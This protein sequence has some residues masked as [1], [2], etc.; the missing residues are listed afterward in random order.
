VAAPPL[1]SSPSLPPDGGANAAWESEVVTLVNQRRAA[2]A[3]CGGLTYGPAPALVV[4][5]ALRAAARGHS[6]D[7]ATQNYF[8]HT[9][10]DGRTFSQRIS[11]AGYMGTY[12]WGE[13]IAA[14]QSSPAAV[15]SGWM[16]SA[17]HCTNIMNP[18]HRAIG[19]GYAYSAASSYR[20]YWTQDFGGS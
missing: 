17:G 11:N 7:M 13:N 9:S 16:N 2:G 6:E 12:P 10:S 8:S 5:T 14:G 3:T 4:N 18:S 1:P 19:V 20:H 15:V